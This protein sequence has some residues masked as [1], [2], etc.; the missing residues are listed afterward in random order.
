MRQLVSDVDDVVL[1]NSFGGSLLAAA[2][3]AGVPLLASL[4]TDGYGVNV[5]R[6]NAPDLP[7]YAK[8]AEWPAVDFGRTAV[9]GHPPCSAFSTL[10][11]GM[12][13]RQSEDPSASVSSE[14]FALTRQLLDYAMDAGAP[15]VM[16]ESVPK[17][18]VEAR[19]VHEEYAE[20]HGYSLVRMLLNSTQFGLPQNRKRFWAIFLKGR[21]RSVTIAPPPNLADDPVPIGDFLKFD[22]PPL[23]CHQQKFERLDG[24]IAER[25]PD[26]ADRRAIYEGERGFGRMKHI[27]T[28]L[29]GDQQWAY[30]ANAREWD[31]RCLK[32]LDPRKPAPVILGSSL[33]MCHGKLLPLSDYLRIMGYPYW[34]AYPAKVTKRAET[35]LQFV[36]R[37]VCPPIAAWLLRNFVT[38]IDDGSRVV[39]H[40][41]VIDWDVEAA[42]I[43]E[44]RDA[45]ETPRVPKA[46]RL[47]K[48]RVRAEEKFEPNP[49]A[50]KLNLS[51][52]LA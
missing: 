38:L 15:V 30:E 6:F 10:N 29:T 36:S 44:A 31:V 12:R 8:R 34:Y 41:D 22:G 40:G 18:L 21:G 49:L 1:I 17:A 45:R 4:E 9:I 27:L 16:I 39:S 20:R 35:T 42:R 24:R 25:F 14:A 26:A 28:E 19:A 51:R 46:E 33:W 47:P 11:S 43:R 2:V 37:G 32:I 3:E 23:A 7:I 50:P 13:K 52:R 48:T 5:Q